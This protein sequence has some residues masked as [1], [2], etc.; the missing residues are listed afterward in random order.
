MPDQSSRPLRLGLRVLD[1]V[2][3]ILRP[4]ADA[5][6][7][8]YRRHHSDLRSVYVIGSVAVGEWTEGVSDLDVVGVI[9]LVGADGGDEPAA[10]VLPPWLECASSMIMANGLPRWSVPISSNTNGNFCNVEMMIFLPLSMNLR[11]SPEWS[12]CPT[13]APTC[14]KFLIVLCS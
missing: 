11:R 14:M 6:V 5:T 12:A 8:C 10:E 9:E 13:V 3:S 4:L 7:A 1:E 2:P